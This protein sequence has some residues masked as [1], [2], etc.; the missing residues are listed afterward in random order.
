[1]FSQVRTELKL[2]SSHDKRVCICD[3]P[4]GV[5]VAEGSEA[6]TF[7]TRSFIVSRPQLQGPPP[8]SQQHLQAKEEVHSALP[9]TVQNRYTHTHTYTCNI[10]VCSQI[11]PFTSMSH[12]WFVI[13]FL[14]PALWIYPLASKE[15]GDSA[16][17]KFIVTLDGVPSPL[18]NLTDCDMELDD[19]RPPTKVTDAPAHINRAPKVSVLHRLQGR[20][21]S[22]EGAGSRLNTSALQ[23]GIVLHIFVRLYF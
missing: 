11:C 16:S 18:G 7:D 21:A 10:G 8:R 15:R 4:L 19:V 17:P 1:M 20:V 2:K 5:K 9:R 14:L 12:C 13:F 6:K 23:F 22:S 3:A